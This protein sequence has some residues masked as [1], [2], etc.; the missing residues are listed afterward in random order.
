MRKTF[1]AFGLLMASTAVSAQN[2]GQTPAAPPAVPQVDQRATR[3]KTQAAAPAQRKINISKPAQ[4]AVID[5]QNAVAAND[6]ATIPAKL[7]AAKAV[8]KTDEDRY[9]IGVL[10]LRHGIAAK[11]NAMIASALEGILASNQ[12]SAEELPLNYLNLGKAYNNLKQP[13]KAIPALERSIQLN[14]SDTEAVIL[15]AETQAARGQV[16]AAVDQLRKA[17]AVKQAS[18]HKADEAWYKRALTLA[19][20]ANLPATPEVARA[21][22]QA[23]PTSANWKDAIRIYRNMA[24]PP[25]PILLD[26]LRLSRVTGSLDGDVDY[27]AYVFIAADQRNAREGKTLLDEAAAAGKIDINKPV[28]QDMLK[29]LKSRPMPGEDILAQSAA[30]QLAGSDGAAL[31]L[32]ANR[33]Y[34]IGNYARAAELFRAALAKPGV[35]KDQVNLQLGIALA[36]AGDKAGAKAAFEAVAGTRAEVAKYWLAYLATKA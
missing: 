9:Y 32:T 36:A 17:I 25:E 10:E 28:Y 19:Y 16:A 21:W 5:L 30:A 24:R 13:E 18:G 29:A 22:I 11:D 15:L 35:D 2:Y 8:A 14:P 6:S 20:K 33:Y 23:Y 1:V 4:K 12:S 7:A 31:L 27:N 26:L 3:A 34:G